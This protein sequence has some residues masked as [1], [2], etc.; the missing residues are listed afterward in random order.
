MNL[1]MIVFVCLCFVSCKKGET[2]GVSDAGAGTRVSTQTAGGMLSAPANYVKTTIQ[3]KDKAKS[4]A[5]AYSKSSSEHM[6]IE[7]D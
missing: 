1:L 3:F 5:D 6:K 2:S 7:G 4:A